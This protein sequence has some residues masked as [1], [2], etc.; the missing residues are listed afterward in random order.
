MNEWMKIEERDMYDFQCWPTHTHTQWKCW[1]DIN[2]ASF[3][4][5]I[6]TYIHTFIWNGS[7]KWAKSKEWV[8]NRNVS[9][10]II[11]KNVKTEKERANSNWICSKSEWEKKWKKPG[12]CVFFLWLG[13]G[14]EWNEAIAPRVET[15]LDKYNVRWTIQTNISSAT[16][17]IVNMDPKKKL[18]QHSFPLFFSL[19]QLEWEN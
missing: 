17:T 6:H 11:T 9:N 2:Y 5:K 13:S 16:I 4:G 12:A 14:L 1:F 3:V 8:G 18:Y 10:L 7:S 15:K 19:F